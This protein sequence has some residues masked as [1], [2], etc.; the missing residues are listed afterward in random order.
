[1]STVVYGLELTLD[2]GLV[3]KLSKCVDD[4]KLC[5]NVSNSSDV[6]SLQNDCLSGLKN[7]LNCLSGLKNGR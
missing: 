5:K 7:G 6:D 3:S 4:S 2:D 1:M